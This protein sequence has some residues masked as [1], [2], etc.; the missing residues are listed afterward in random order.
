MQ[1]DYYFSTCVVMEE[2][3]Y[4]GLDKINNTVVINWS[5]DSS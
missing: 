3:Y 5:H 2:N 4:I 1:T